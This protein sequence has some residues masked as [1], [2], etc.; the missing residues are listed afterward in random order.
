MMLI[1][2][3]AQLDTKARMALREIFDAVNYSFVNHEQ[4]PRGFTSAE[5][6]VAHE[7]G[8]RK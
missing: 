2:E 6:A 1:S 5:K 8:H 3:A 7:N 4:H